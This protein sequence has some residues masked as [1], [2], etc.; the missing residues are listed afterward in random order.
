M[1]VQVKPVRCLTVE[2]AAER[3]GKSR[4]SL[5]EALDKRSARFDPRFPRPF[6]CGGRRTY[7]LESEIEGWIMEK[8]AAARGE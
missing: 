4:S 1:E 7:F 5:Y 6:K 8:V 2:Q 3:A